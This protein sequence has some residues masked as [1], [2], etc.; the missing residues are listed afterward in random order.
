MGFLAEAKQRWGTAV[1]PFFIKW[2]LIGGAL[3]TAGAGLTFPNFT[4][5]FTWLNYV[6]P[7]LIGLGSGIAV[8]S[9][10]VMKVVAILAPGDS[11]HNDTGQPI[12]VSAAPTVGAPPDGL[13]VTKT[14]DAIV[15]EQGS[16]S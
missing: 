16:T 3:V 8:I 1:P 12:A 10:F 9:Q 5:K 15:T 14:G 13:V 7:G 6:G 11:L 4:G 2:Q